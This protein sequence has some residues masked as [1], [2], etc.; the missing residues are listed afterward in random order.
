MGPLL[1]K[2]NGGKRQ[3]ATKGPPATRPKHNGWSAGIDDRPAGTHEWALHNAPWG[4]RAYPPESKAPAVIERAPLAGR[5]TPPTGNE[6]RWDWRQPSAMP[7][8]LPGHK[9]RTD[10]RESGEAPSRLGASVE[11]DPNARQFLLGDL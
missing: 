7:R 8:G 1:Q 5:M 11:A 4:G 2:E 10:R 3:H 6:G 9:R